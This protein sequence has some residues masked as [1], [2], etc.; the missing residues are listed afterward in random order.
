MFVSSSVSLWLPFPFISNSSSTLSFPFL[1]FLLFFTSSWFSNFRSFFSFF[2]FFCLSSFRSLLFF[3]LS[4]FSSVIPFSSAF[5]FS[6]VSAGCRSSFCCGLSCSFSFEVFCWK[7]DNY[8]FHM[9][10]MTW[11]LSSTRSSVTVQ[12]TDILKSIKSPT[13]DVIN[14]LRSSTSELMCLIL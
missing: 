9:C 14:Y 12:N 11:Q 8:S 6:P 10:F 7:K 1:D 13:Y 5:V 2:L 3:F 4:V